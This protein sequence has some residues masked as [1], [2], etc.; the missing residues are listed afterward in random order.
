MGHRLIAR[1]VRTRG[2]A[3]VSSTAVA[4]SLIAIGSAPSAAERLPEVGSLCSVEQFWNVIPVGKDVDKKTG[5][6]TLVRI[7]KNSPSE[8][9]CTPLGF[10]DE[11]DF[12]E[13]EPKWGTWEF[14]SR[15][16]MAQDMG[17]YPNESVL[18]LKKRNDPCRLTSSLQTVHLGWRDARDREGYLDA[19][20]VAQGLVVHAA[21]PEN[22]DLLR[23][24]DEVVDDMR[25]GLE[26]ANAY[27][28]AQSNGWF[29]LELDF[30][31]LYVPVSG[32][33]ANG[34]SYEYWRQVEEQ[35]SDQYDLP[36]YDFVV[37]TT[38][39]GGGKMVPLRA[40]NGNW[41][42]GP[43]HM[44]LMGRMDPSEYRYEYLLKHEV[45]HALGLV[46][47][48][49]RTPYAGRW[50]K[51]STAM[52][53]GNDYL[54]AYERWIT[55]WIPDQRVIC[56]DAAK[57][58]SATLR[59][60]EVRDLSPTMVVFRLSDSQAVVVENRATSLP[61]DVPEG[62]YLYVYW[63]NAQSVGNPFSTFPWSSPQQGP[64]L[65]TYRPDLSS[66]EV[67]ADFPDAS[68][69]D[70]D[71][72][73]EAIA[74]WKERNPWM[75]QLHQ[76]SLFAPSEDESVPAT[77]FG[78]TLPRPVEVESGSGS[79]AALSFDYDFEPEPFDPDRD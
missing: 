4:A 48:Y 53:L 74:E 75:D 70:S 34:S 79:R 17:K 20:R 64:P 55:G 59:S 29:G 5:S 6:V 12:P 78:L 45:G 43:T 10:P 57:S 16:L 37:V 26:N 24:A 38:P 21:D 18:G 30:T 76:S 47:L 2:L 42:G 51:S 8:L 52:G 3:I 32:E 14:R 7:K 35:I 60:T 72:W 66:L 25:Q 69:Y 9:V 49:A 28:A 71:G 65:I 62:A 54:T 36:G 13:V 27:W 1:S 41:Q 39:S 58:G 46:D 56:I 31:R 44:I 22:P 40:G 50:V 23:N 73:Y 11:S 68:N 61:S 19:D 15:G 67:S 33:S 77:W 63:V